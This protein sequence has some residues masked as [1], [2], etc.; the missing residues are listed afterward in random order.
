MVNY[1]IAL[2]HVNALKSQLAGLAREAA[3]ALDDE[4]V[5]AMEGLMIGQRGLLFAMT[6]MTLLKG[7]PPDE[8]QRVIHVLE[9]A[10]FTMP[11]Q[12]GEGS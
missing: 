9:H 7:M 6:L 1:D 12:V 3:N 11:P 10:L 5:T 2:Y 4:T 8:V